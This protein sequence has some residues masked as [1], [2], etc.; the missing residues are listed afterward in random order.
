MKE[1]RLDARAGDQAGD[2]VFVA[3]NQHLAPRQPRHCQPAPAPITYCYH[4][5]K[6]GGDAVG[7]GPGVVGG[8]EHVIAGL[9]AGPGVQLMF[10]HQLDA[11]LA[12]GDLLAA[13][14][15][16]VDVRERAFGRPA[17]RPGAVAALAAEAAAAV[18]LAPPR[19][20]ALRAL[21]HRGPAGGVT[22]GALGPPVAGGRALVVAL[23]AVVVVVPGVEQAVVVAQ[24]QVLVAGDVELRGVVGSR[25][26]GRAGR[27]STAPPAW[28]GP[29]P[30]ERSGRSR[31]R[32][33]R[34]WPCPCA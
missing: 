26:W 8:H 2:D 5:A 27:R 16:A 7:E 10:L 1:H 21:D 6:D 20:A 14:Q 12:E 13:G 29:R 23:A 24:A 22:G 4:T 9:A 34:S 25:A 33:P 18:V 11:A 28:S 31:R 30:V 17:H 19:R 32:S 15:A 3:T